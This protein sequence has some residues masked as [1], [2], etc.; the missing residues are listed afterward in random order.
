MSAHTP[1]FTK[2]NSQLIVL[3]LDYVGLTLERSKYQAELNRLLNYAAQ[4]Y[5]SFG[6][7][8]RGG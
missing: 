6:G 7:T 8:G 5:R 4:K 1:G 3:C 2:R